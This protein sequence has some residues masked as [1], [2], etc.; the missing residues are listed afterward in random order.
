MY[1]I[2]VINPGSSS[3]KVAVFEDEKRSLKRISSTAL[4]S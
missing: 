2:L 4:K 3:T 1:R